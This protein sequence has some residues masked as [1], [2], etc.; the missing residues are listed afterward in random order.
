VNGENL[1]QGDGLA[2]SDEVELSILAG[3]EGAE[4][5]FFELG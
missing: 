3:S 1:S 2:I 4:V 5:L